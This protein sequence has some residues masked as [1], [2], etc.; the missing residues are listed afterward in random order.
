MADRGLSMKTKITNQGDLMIV[1]LS[2]YLDFETAHPIAQSIE[3]LYKD[4]KQA[5]VIIDMSALEF[6]GSSGLANF[7]KNL[8]VFNKLKMKPA[9]FGVKSEFIK[10]FRVFEEHHPFEVVEDREAA[11]SAALARFEEWQARTLRSARTH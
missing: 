3:V 4:N 10:L 1:E 9:Y 8:R 7:V 5:K 11:A 6:V 2:G